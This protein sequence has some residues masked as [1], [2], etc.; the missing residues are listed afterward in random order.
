MKRLLSI[1]SVVLVVLLLTACRNNIVYSRFQSVAHPGGMN[2]SSDKWHMD[3][4]VSFAYHI[5]DTSADYQMIVYIRHTERFPYQNM[6]LFVGD[7]LLRDTIEFYLADDRGL[8]L[9]DKH[10]GFIEMP[11]LLEEAK[12]FP[13]TGVYY[14]NIQH[15][16][17]DS[18]LR[19]VT[20][21]GLE[22]SR[23]G[24]E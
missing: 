10:N 8:W 6:W 9:G 22:I 4:T 20:D 19:G 24:Q 21:V 17:R 23:H 5:A 2:P 16:M 14:L 1:L 12:H 18:L 15:A 3:S 7:S 13:D 11:V